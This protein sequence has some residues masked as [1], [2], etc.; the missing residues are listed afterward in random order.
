MR[1]FTLG[2]LSAFAIFSTGCCLRV[3]DTRVGVNCCAVK[4]SETFVADQDIDPA[5]VAVDPAAPATK[6]DNA[7][8]A[9]I[10]VGVGIAGLIGWNA[11]NAIQK[12]KAKAAAP[13]VKEAKS[14]TANK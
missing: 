10:V 6:D 7:L 8:L 11:Y 14:E 3:M 4:D 9:A 13:V 5:T 12:K 1:K 2:V